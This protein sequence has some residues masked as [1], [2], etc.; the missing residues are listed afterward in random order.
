MKPRDVYSEG[1]QEIGTAVPEESTAGASAAEWND[2]ERDTDPPKKL[3]RTNTI[4]RRAANTTQTGV[5]IPRPDDIVVSSGVEGGPK[6]LDLTEII[7]ADITKMEVIRNKAK[8]NA[9][10]LLG[11]SNYAGTRKQKVTEENNGVPSSTDAHT[12]V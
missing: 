4:H 2:C 11:K 8:E 1:T 9:G 3:S 10:T 5:K 6:E 7:Y 12:Q